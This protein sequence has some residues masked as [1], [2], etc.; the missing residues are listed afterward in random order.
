MR[1]T[2]CRMFIIL[3]ILHL[4]SFSRLL[5]VLLHVSRVPS[6]FSINAPPM[7]YRLNG[8]DW[9]EKKEKKLIV[10]CCEMANLVNATGGSGI[11]R[12]LQTELSEFP[13]NARY[14]LATIAQLHPL[15]HCQQRQTQD[16]RILAHSGPHFRH[17]LQPRQILRPEEQDQQ[18][19][20][21]VRVAWG[22]TRQSRDAPLPEG[23]NREGRRGELDRV[24]PVARQ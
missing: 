24:Y 1:F 16:A 8:V 17:V 6:V 5:P 23:E 21:I 11:L 4:Q 14:L 15:P 13:K 22:V 12:R 20:Q 19:T 18:I 10:N 9:F 3:R 7:F 2:C